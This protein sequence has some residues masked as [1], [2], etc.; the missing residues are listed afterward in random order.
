MDQNSQNVVWINNSRNAW[1]TCIL[2]LILSF[3]DNLLLDAYIIYQKGVDNFDIEH[4]NAN[5][6]L[7][8]AV[9]P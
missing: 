2:M 7:G 8:G 6:G 3:L 4:K 9:P 1:P 5:F